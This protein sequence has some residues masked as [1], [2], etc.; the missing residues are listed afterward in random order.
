[1]LHRCPILLVSR[2]QHGN[3]IVS[4]RKC[5]K[6]SNYIARIFNLDFSN[7]APLDKYLVSVGLEK[8]ELVCVG[9]G[10]EAGLIYRRDQE[11]G[12]SFSRLFLILRA[13][14]PLNTLH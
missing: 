3:C 2:L 13:Q 12:A 11:D 7:K 9:M 10:I 5:R 1:L 4:P 6:V 8:L 14:L